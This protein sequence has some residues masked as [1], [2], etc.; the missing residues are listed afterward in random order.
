MQI[1]FKNECGRVN[2]VVC[3]EN[4]I[5]EIQENLFALIFRKQEI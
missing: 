2:C 3:L 4:Q 1:P 5:S